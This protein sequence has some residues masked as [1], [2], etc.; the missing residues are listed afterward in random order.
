MHEYIIVPC[1]LYCQGQFTSLLRDVKPTGH[2]RLVPRLKMVGLYL[3]SSIRLRHRETFTIPLVYF[4][5]HRCS[6][7]HYE[8]NDCKLIT[9]ATDR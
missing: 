9:I 6:T 3:H 5:T 8:S 2:L 4:F 1:V 7:D